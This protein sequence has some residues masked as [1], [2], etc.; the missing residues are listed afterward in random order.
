MI[1]PELV[2]DWNQVLVLGTE[3]KS[4]FDIGIEAE[5]F[6][7]FNQLFFSIFFQFFNFF[8]TSSDNISIYKLEPKSSK[9][10]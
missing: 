3:T 6:F 1:L 4:N 5:I 10:I 2:C 8:S 7:F 9:I